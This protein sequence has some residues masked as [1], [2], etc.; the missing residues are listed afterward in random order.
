[1]N[2]QSTAPALVLFRPICPVLTVLPIAAVASLAS[3]TT[4]FAIATVPPS[5][6]AGAPLQVSVMAPPVELPD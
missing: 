1:M 6:A 4:L 3:L 5:P 2:G